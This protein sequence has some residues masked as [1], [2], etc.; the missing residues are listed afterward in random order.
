MELNDYDVAGKWEEHSERITVGHPRIP[1][2]G[3]LQISEHRPPADPEKVGCMTDND[4]DCLAVVSFSLTN[5]PVSCLVL[6]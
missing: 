4:L 5:S 6:L 3:V 2:A 1:P